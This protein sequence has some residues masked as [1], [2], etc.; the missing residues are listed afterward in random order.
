[1]ASSSAGR[2]LQTVKKHVPSIRFPSRMGQNIKPGPAP[3]ND[4]NPEVSSSLSALSKRTIPTS[5]S[6]VDSVYSYESLPTRYRRKP[7]TQ[8]EIEYIENG[9]PI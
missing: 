7:L 6:P 4:R 3:S 1:M 2:I 9:G 8:E 5:T